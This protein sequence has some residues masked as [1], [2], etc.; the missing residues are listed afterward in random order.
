MKNKMIFICL[1]MIFI[2]NLAS[3]LYAGET[4][5][6]DL[7]DKFIDINETFYEIIGNSTDLNGLYISINKTNLT[8]TLSKD[9]KPDKFSIV[10]WGNKEQ[11]S[12]IIPI[13]EQSSGGSGCITTW[14]GCE[15]GVAVKNDYII[16]N[17]KISG[18]YCYAPAKD[19]PNCTTQKTTEQITPQVTESSNT[20]EGTEPPLLT[21]VDANTSTGK[22]SFKNYS[23]WNWYVIGAIILG[24]VFII[25]IIIKNSIKNE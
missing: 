5:T 16:G 6:Y 18:K 25:I 11:S 22:F 19:K 24:I 15:N 10:V 23:S 12:V 20:S 17:V 13:K 1:E 14:K 8:I 21:P 2:L 9:F 7:S 4:A 3:A